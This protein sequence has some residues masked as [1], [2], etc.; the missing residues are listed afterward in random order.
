MKA[1]LGFC[2]MLLLAP[3]AP[4]CKKERA[5][6]NCLL[7][8]LLPGL[9]ANKPPVARAGPDQVVKL[10]TD[11]TLLDGRASYDSDGR[12]VAWGW[13]QVDGPMAA[14]VSRT[15]AA[16]TLLRSLVQ[17]RYAFELK[18]TDDRGGSAQDT[19]AVDVQIDTGLNF[20]IRSRSSVH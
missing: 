15:D 14:K 8:G 3:A 18:V 4:A 19:V 2:S 5:C 17:G 12:V 13:R 11:S 10:P 6:E 16:V 7:N 20:P 9:P 1:L